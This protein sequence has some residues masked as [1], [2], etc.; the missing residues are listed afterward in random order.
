MKKGEANEKHGDDIRLVYPSEYLGSPDLRGR[1]VKVTI[2]S[3][4]VEGVQSEDGKLAKALLRFRGAGKPWI[5]NKTNLRRIASLHGTKPSL[6]VG[7]E[8]TLYPT[9]CQ[10]PD[11]TVVECVRAMPSPSFAYPRKDVEYALTDVGKRLRD[12]RKVTP[13]PQQQ[14]TPKQ[15]DAKA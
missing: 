4:A 7:K 11:G 9:A 13:G 3:F 10:S 8:I 2:E 1:A 14:A 6:W 5:A 15:E 12:A